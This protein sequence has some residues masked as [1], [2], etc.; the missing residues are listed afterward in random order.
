MASKEYDQI[1]LKLDIE[2]AEYKVLKD[3]IRKNAARHIDY[4][5]VEFHGQ[6]FKD[7]EKAHYRQLE[8][9]LVRELKLSGMGVT[10]WV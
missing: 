5:F 4:L 3:I 6:Y 7:S 9:E 8:K 2:S 1:I 10:L